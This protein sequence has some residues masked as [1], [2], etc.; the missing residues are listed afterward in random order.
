MNC[1]YC[2][3]DINKSFPYIETEAYP[4]EGCSTITLKKGKVELS[5][6]EVDDELYCDIFCFINYIKEYF[7]ENK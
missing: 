7:N 5:R 2:N 3:S 1:K 4:N 6:L